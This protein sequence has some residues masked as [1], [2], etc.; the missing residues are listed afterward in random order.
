MREIEREKD[1]QQ[2]LDNL[3]HSINAATDIASIAIATANN[4]VNNS[5]RKRKPI[6]YGTLHLNLTHPK[7]FVR[8]S[9]CCA[10]VFFLYT[11]ACMQRYTFMDTVLTMKLV[12]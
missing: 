3:D 7:R 5:M 8:V 9:I 11:S 2:F 4:M 6:A 10:H 1:P 12:Q